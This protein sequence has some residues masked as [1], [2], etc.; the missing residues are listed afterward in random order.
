MFVPAHADAT[1]EIAPLA[2]ANI[3]KVFEISDRILEICKEPT[4]FE[5]N[6]LLWERL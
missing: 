2:Q 1:K 4:V 3:D 5:N 6:H